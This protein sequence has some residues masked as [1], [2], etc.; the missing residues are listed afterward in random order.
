MSPLCSLDSEDTRVDPEL[1]ASA[2]GTDG[3]Q[4]QR[5]V[6]MR[7]S[8]AASDRLPVVQLKSWT[9]RSRSSNRALSDDIVDFHQPDASGVILAG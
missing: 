1:N 4:R 8:Y 9:E 7:V 6:N 2:L 5:G 3:T